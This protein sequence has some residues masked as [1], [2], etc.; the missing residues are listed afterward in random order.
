MRSKV[1]L[2]V[3]FASG[4]LLPIYESLIIYWEF[5]LRISY[6]FFW[7]EINSR[8]YFVCRAIFD[9]CKNRIIIQTDTSAYDLFLRLVSRELPS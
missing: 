2:L 8:C 3:L 4:R 5:D 7:Q 1:T 6:N 9:L